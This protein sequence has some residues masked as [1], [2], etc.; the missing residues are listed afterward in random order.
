MKKCLLA[1]GLAL[2]AVSAVYA[3]KTTNGYI[4]YDAHALLSVPHSFAYSDLLSLLDIPLDMQ[5]LGRF[6]NMN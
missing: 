1:F 6:L 4:R 5:S 3:Q 2:A